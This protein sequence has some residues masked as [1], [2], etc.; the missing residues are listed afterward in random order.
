MLPYI[1]PYILLPSLH[2]NRTY[3]SCCS[4]LLPSLPCTYLTFSFLRPTC[5]PC[6]PS[7]RPK[8]CYEYVFPYLTLPESMFLRH[9][10]HIQG[11]SKYKYGK[12]SQHATPIKRAF[13]G[14]LPVRFLSWKTCSR[15]KICF[16][17]LKKW[18]DLSFLGPNVDPP[19]FLFPDL[20]LKSR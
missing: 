16:F 5:L 18:L 4:P 12:C 10:T 1:P 11:W 9:R 7:T 14:P 8:N 17:F 2:L 6:R 15:L 20:T 3:L 19:I 13:P